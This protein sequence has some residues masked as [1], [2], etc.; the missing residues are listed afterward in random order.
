MQL[1]PRH[2]ILLAV[3]IGLFVFNVVRHRHAQQPTTFTRTQPVVITARPNFPVWTA[4]D[5][6]ATLRDAPEPQFQ[7][8]FQNLQ[9]QIAA[10]P[11]Q[12]G[13]SGCVTWL[14]FYRQGILH[15]ARDPQWK[16]RSEHHLDGC[17]Q[18]HADTSA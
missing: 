11:A 13:I 8:A 18:H 6:A 7:P 17:I 12:P 2:F 3:V 4:F 10:A 14:E 16:S 5:H 9:Q 15:P 1:R